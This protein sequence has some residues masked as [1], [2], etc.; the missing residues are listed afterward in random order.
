MPLL[1]LTKM[2]VWQLLLYLH[3]GDNR[4]AKWKAPPQRPFSIDEESKEEEIPCVGRRWPSGQSTEK[5]NS[6]TRVRSYGRVAEETHMLLLNPV[7]DCEFIRDF[8]GWHEPP[9]ALLKKY[10]TN[11]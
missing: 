7:F 3:N 8:R 6:M 5:E 1:D 4:T 2:S 11:H 10:C 9:E